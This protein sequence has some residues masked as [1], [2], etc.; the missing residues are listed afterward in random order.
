MMMF[1]SMFLARKTILA[2]SSL[3]WFWAFTLFLSPKNVSAL[4]AVRKQRRRKRR[5]HGVPPSG[6]ARA[7]VP[8]LGASSPA[9]RF[10][11]PYLYKASASCD[12]HPAFAPR[13]HR[14]I[15]SL[16]LR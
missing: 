8:T 2:T 5:R 12:L 14:T 10:V 13:L 16:G 3:L 1:S 15:F 6:G 4:V 9:G 11:L 7:V